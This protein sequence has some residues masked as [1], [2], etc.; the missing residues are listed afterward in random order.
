MYVVLWRVVTPSRVVI[1]CKK[2]FRM[3]KRKTAVDSDGDANAIRCVCGNDGD[4]GFSIA[5]DECSRWVHGACFGMVDGNHVPDVWKCWVCEGGSGSRERGVRVRGTVRRRRR[6]TEDEPGTH[7]YVPIA[8]DEVPDAEVRLRLRQY[9]QAWR[10]LCA[11]NGPSKTAVRGMRSGEEKEAVRPPGYRLHA[12]SCVRENELVA[13][14]RSRIIPSSVYLLDS[15]NGYAHLGMPKP[16]VHLIGP[17]LDVALDARICGSD[18]RFAR[19]GCRPNAVV[20]PCLH[21]D[22][23]TLTFGLFAL[24]D[25]K[26]GEEVV[27]GWEWDDANVV[28]SLPALIQ[29][30]NLF[31][32]VVFLLTCAALTL[33]RPSH[34]NRLRHQLSNLLHALSST[35]TTCACGVNATHCALTQIAAFVDAVHPHSSD[36]GP[37]VGTQRGFRTRERLV[38]ASGIGGVEMVHPP[39]Q[40]CIPPKLRKQWKRPRT[41]PP[42]LLH[43]PSHPPPSPKPLS[44]SHPPPLSPSH[45][46]PLSLSHPSPLSPA[47]T[48]ITTPASSDF[49]SPFPPPVPDKKVKISLKDFAARKRKQRAEDREEGELVEDV[50]PPE[51]SAVL[52]SFDSSALDTTTPTRL[53]SSSSSSSSSDSTPVRPSSFLS[54]PFFLF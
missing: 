21:P 2:P 6:R 3:E 19:S 8:V 40:H 26:P 43:S 13:P 36:L 15:L 14:L 20:R 10:G 12:S 24:R 4:D 23:P 49:S 18:A 28:H 27:L 17:P 54:P 5:C 39:D 32:C 33:S 44:P 38:S 50:K 22:S 47:S 29:S 34:L 16:F 9:G 51:L 31:P 11:L 1:F 35:Y 45:P 42:P 41:L 30:P 53:S 37:L 7:A 25:L 48:T 46:P 52:S